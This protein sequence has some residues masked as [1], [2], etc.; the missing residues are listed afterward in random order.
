MN[1]APSIGT[2]ITDIFRGLADYATDFVPRFLTAI[3]ALGIGWLIATLIR[4]LFRAFLTRV[5]FDDLLEKAGIVKSLERIGL[6]EKPSR[7]LPRVI[8]Y[9]LIVLFVR[10]ASQIIGLEEISDTITTF[11]SYLPNIVAACIVILFGNGVAQFVGRAVATSAENSGIDY[12]R[13]LGRLVSGLI[14]FVVI[15]LAIGQLRIDMAVVNALVLIIFAAFGLSAA[16][17]FGLGTRQITRN[18]VAGFYVR[19]AFKV[20]ESVEID[21]LRGTVRAF[22]PILTILEIDGR[23]VSVSNGAFVRGAVR[24]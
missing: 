20:G 21:G 3:V 11:F 4:R 24:A 10:T 14:F 22:T 16:L 17:T 5:R 19:K 18:I 6:K 8:F 1:D 2:I 15:I 12:A 9:L 13:V 23:S 7:W